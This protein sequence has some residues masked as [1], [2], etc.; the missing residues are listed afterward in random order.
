MDRLSPFEITDRQF[1]E[2][3]SIVKLN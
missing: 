3:K 1:N 2:E